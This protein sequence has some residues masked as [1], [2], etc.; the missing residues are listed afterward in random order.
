MENMGTKDWFFITVT[1]YW[2]RWHLKSPA[3]RWFAQP[4]VQTQI[5]ENNRAPR[6]WLLWGNSPVTG[7]FP[8]Q[9][10]SNAGNVFSFDDVIIFLAFDTFKPEETQVKFYSR[11]FQSH[12]LEGKFLYWYS[13]GITRTHW[14]SMV[15]SLFE[16]QIKWIKRRNMF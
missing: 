14:V 5:K 4:F 10:A 16:L 7:E 2:V 15:N 12:L 6:L 11:Y 3:S 1:S 9:R 8:S 13:N